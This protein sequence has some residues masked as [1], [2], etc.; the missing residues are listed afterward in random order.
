M[1]IKFDVKMTE[2]I[3][4][5]FL[6]HH[7]YNNASVI[8]GNVVGILVALLGVNAWTENPGDGMLNIVLGV[9]VLVY[10]PF[11][12]YMSANK[13]IKTSEVFKQPITYTVSEQG[14]TSA[15][16]DVTTEAK[17]EAVEKVV[18]TSKSIVVYTGKNKATILPKEA[19]GN[20]YETVVQIISTHVEPKK[21][22]IRS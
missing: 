15:Q 13:Q 20:D 2:K 19:M 21:V 22:K 12:L 18:S 1:S 17:W 14:L 10:T 7:A 5:N 6:L 8:I 16:N 11:S 4:Y 9:V 3:M